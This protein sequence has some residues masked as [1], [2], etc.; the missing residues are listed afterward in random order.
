MNAPELVF[1]GIDVAKDTLELALDDRSPTRPMSN[2]VAGI[3]QLSEEL[4]ALGARVGAVV[5]E[6]TGSYERQVAV[7]L[8]IAFAVM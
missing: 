6:A 3:A 1:V 5:I 7:A 4:V 8:C 2:D